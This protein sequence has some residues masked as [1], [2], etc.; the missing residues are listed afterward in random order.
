MKDG[1]LEGKLLFI[2]TEGTFAPQRAV[3]VLAT[4]LNDFDD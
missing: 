4:G 2:D 1:G 3:I